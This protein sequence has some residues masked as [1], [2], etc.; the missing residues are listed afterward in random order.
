MYK[1]GDKVKLIIDTY[2][3]LRKGDIGVIK[4]YYAPEEV[5]LV[6]WNNK[7][8]YWIQKDCIKLINKVKNQPERNRV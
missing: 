6:S 8:N 1:I 5:F 4:N 3:R 7:S 2:S